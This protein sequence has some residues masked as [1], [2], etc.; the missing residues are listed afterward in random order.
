MLRGLD[1][2]SLDGLS[3]DT[4]VRWIEDSLAAGT[5]RLASGYQGQTLLYENAGRRLVIKVPI[6]RGPRRW[7]ATLLLR[8]EARVYACLDGFTGAPKYYGLLKNRY[9]VL[10]YVEGVSARTAAYVDRGAF[11]SE[12]LHF[13]N[14]LH[15]RGIAHSDL[16]K[17][18]NLLVV[19]GSTPCLLDFGTAVIRKPGFAPI[20]RLHYRLAKRLDINQYIKLKYRKRFDALSAADQALYQRTTVEK[21]ARALKRLWRQVR[22][23]APNRRPRKKR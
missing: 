2:L 8:H 16:Q 12:L 10:A 4:L 7:I 1:G 14:E 9:L 11:F 19:A 5:H 13:I 17:K 18:D 23:G 22:Y 3:E 21:V 6:G 20:N 15:R